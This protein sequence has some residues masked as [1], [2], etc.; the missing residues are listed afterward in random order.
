VRQA[1]SHPD[2]DP[3]WQLMVDADLPVCVHLIVRFDRA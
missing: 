2:F 3:L 1:A